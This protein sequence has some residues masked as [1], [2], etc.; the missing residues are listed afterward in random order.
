MPSF[1][2]QLGM[3]A[4]DSALRSLEK[5]AHKRSM[6]IEKRHKVDL[7]NQFLPENVSQLILS[8]PE[9]DQWGAIQAL[10]PEYANEGPGQN[11]LGMEQIQQ[12]GQL[13]PMGPQGAPQ[14][15]NSLLQQAIKPSGNAGQNSSLMQAIQQPLQ[16]QQ[17]TTQAQKQAQPQQQMSERQK[18]GK[19]LGQKGVSA[20][21]D[22][23]VQKKVDSATELLQIADEMEKLWKTKKVS[24]GR[25]GAWQKR[26][27]PTIW[28]PNEE[29]NT[30]DS[31]GSQA[32]ILEASLIPGQTTNE[33]LKAAE[34]T[35]P[36]I[37]Q[38]EKTQLSRINAMRKKAQDILKKYGGSEIESQI[39]EEPKKKMIT[40]LPDPSSVPVGKQYRKNGKTYTN[41]GTTF[42]VS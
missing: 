40:A 22:K 1:L 36:N 9:K 23:D 35:K 2:S 29:T 11:Q 19:A 26:L 4:G 33:K 34:R 17:E 30:F 7:L 41:T 12:Q 20:K 28:E 3:A 24:A 31:L 39:S 8:L 5:V 27:G 25:K 42:T 38:N 21:M 13:G 14:D 32:A 15:I 16:G 18:F 6:D 37:T 10:A